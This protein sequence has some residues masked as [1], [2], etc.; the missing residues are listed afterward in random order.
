MF[1]N[2]RI[3]ALL[4]VLVLTLLTVQAAAQSLRIEL[5]NGF[6]QKYHDRV[7][8]DARLRV[9][10]PQT[11]AHSPSKD[12]EVHL[13][14]VTVEADTGQDIGFATVAEIMHAKQFEGNGGLLKWIATTNQPVRMRGVWRIWAEHGGENSTYTQGQYPSP[15]TWQPKSNPSH[16]FELHPLTQVQR[17]SQTVS[18][19]N[20]FKF[21]PGFSDPQK[22]NRT[23]GAFGYFEQIA[24]KIKPGPQQ[25][26]ITCEPHRYNFVGFTAQLNGSPVQTPTNDGLLAFADIYDQ[27]GQ[28]LPHGQPLAR[29]VRLVF[30][31][32]TPPASKVLAL[33]GNSDRIKLVG[34]PRLNLTVVQRVIDATQEYQG[35]LPY[36]MVVTWLGSN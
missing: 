19:L 1:N 29:N 15:L 28:G 20:D 4:A 17:N 2:R 7:V 23:R 32:G 27:N 13:S 8:M 10:G 26:R 36:E 25:T 24:C 30:T 9:V 22:I 6:V 35:K 33:N 21:L 3:W 14:G 18:L 16:V 12:G 11:V 31:A 34:F 5:D